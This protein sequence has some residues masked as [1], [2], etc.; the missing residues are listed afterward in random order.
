MSR[1]TLICAALTAMDAQKR[2]WQDQRGQMTDQQGGTM[3]TPASK[4][5]STHQ[6]QAS[7]EDLR[8]QYDQLLVEWDEASR[9]G[10]GSKADILK[11]KLMQMAPQ[12]FGG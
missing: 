7:R 8:L 5:P 12:V 6:P 4:Q 1:I 3:S 10:E 2:V 9:T 11:R